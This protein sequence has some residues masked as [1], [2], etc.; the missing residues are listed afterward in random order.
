ADIKIARF[1][2]NVKEFDLAE[3]GE[4]AVSVVQEFAHSNNI[5]IACD[6]KPVSVLGDFDRV[7]QVAINLLSNAIKF[8][9]A[10]GKIYVRAAVDSE[11]GTFSV[12][13]EGPGIPEQFKKRIFNR[14]EQAGSGNQGKGPGTGLGLAISKELMVEQKGQLV[15]QSPAQNGIGSEFSLSLPRASSASAELS[16]KQSSKQSSDHSF[17]H[18]SEPAASPGAAAQSAGGRQFKP[19][20]LWLKG[21]L[22]LAIPLLIYLVTTAMLLFTLHATSENIEELSRS[23]KIA[24]LNSDL[25]VQYTTGWNY[26]IY[27]NASRD[28]EYLKAALKTQEVGQ[29]NLAELERYAANDK[30]VA[31]SLN[32]LKECVNENNRVQNDL[33]AAKDELSANQWFGSL[34][35]EKESSTLNLMQG[36]MLSTI[37]RESKNIEL[38]SA[39]LRELHGWTDQ[40]LLWSAVLS[41]I[42]SL[43]L[44][45]LLA[46]RWRKRIRPIIENL[47]QLARGEAPS[48]LLY[49]DDELAKID[50]ALHDAAAKMAEL[51]KFK[52][53][54][55][56]V[57]S[58]EL[59]TPLTSLAAMTEMIEAN[60][61]G[62][63]TESGKMDLKNA[64]AQ[65]ADLIF[66]ITNLL[67]LEKMLSGKCLVQKESLLVPDIFKKVQTNS[68]RAALDRRIEIESQ[69]APSKVTADPRRLVQAL[70][71]LVRHYIDVVPE[72]S[73]IRLQCET[74]SSGLG[75]IVSTPKP[76]A[77]DQVFD[78]FRARHS[79][80]EHLVEEL[81]R[82]I[83]E[84]H[85][86]SLSISDEGAQRFYRLRL[87]EG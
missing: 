62:T 49:G 8:S 75:L 72:Q 50:G 26:A 69:P 7:K 21:V 86:G 80:R 82:A 37:E 67:D 71:A 38:K 36:P 52:S 58:H 47:D 85:G 41:G 42:A 43:V 29:R 44:S 11:M 4:S 60:M 83:V 35:A 45:A 64:E 2:L 70:T 63:L 78:L 33:L 24:T 3:L 12:R 73:I 14:F 30:N 34:M 16:S 22:L 13:D 84:Q 6:F 10:G 81:S 66:T 56:A 59:R 51:A 68:E 61:F 76:S 25:I 17:D 55:L 5:E 28:P 19:Q 77:T 32:V 48:N 23:R 18:S 15:F 87:A 46:L 54:L 31:S 79:A 57:T 9:P 40:I 53:E 65:N 20:G 39:R 1:E 74:L 27:Y